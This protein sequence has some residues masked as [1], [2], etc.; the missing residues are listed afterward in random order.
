MGKDAPSKAMSALSRAAI[1]TKMAT[2]RLRSKNNLSPHVS[3]SF[4]YVIDE[5]GE[6]MIAGGGY[7]LLS[8][9][10]PVLPAR[11]QRVYD[12]STTLRL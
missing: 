3:I 8:S 5:E 11:L 2:G 10:S 6:A 4:L 7:Y 1:T 12:K 9:S